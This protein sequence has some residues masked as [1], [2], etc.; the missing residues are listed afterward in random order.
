E[1]ETEEELEIR[2]RFASG[3]PFVLDDK[4]FLSLPG[5]R[6]IALAGLNIDEATARLQAVPEIAQYELNLTLLPLLPVGTAA[7][8][9]FG[10]DLFTGRPITF[11][12]ATDIPV[13]AEYVMGPGD[14]VAVQ[15]FGS[16]NVE[17]R[18]A[19]TRDG[20]LNLPEVGPLPVG[21]VTFEELK[22]L[23]NDRILEQLSGVKVSI[24]LGE[25]RSIRIFVLGDANSPGS[26]TV[27]ALSNMTNALFV[28]GGIT[29][30][31]SLRQIALRRNGVTI[32]TMDLYDLLLYG[33]TRAD[34]RLQPGDVIFIPPIGRTVAVDGMVKRPAIYELV[35]DETTVV[36]VIAL[37]GGL[38]PAADRSTVKVER[39]I[40]GRGSLVRDIDLHTEVGAGEMIQDGDVV[41][42]LSNIDQLEDVVRLAGNVQQ[43]GLFEWTPGMRL[44][45][46]LVGSELLR[47]MSDLGY[48]FI[49]REPM[50]NISI[51]AL[52][53]SLSEAWTNPG[54]PEDV[55][56]QPLDTVHVF[57]LEQGRSHIIGP[58]LKEIVS[59]NRTMPLATI[60][61]EV[62]DPGDY[63]LEEGMR[64]TDLIRASG[65]LLESSY[66]LNLEIVRYETPDNVIR[67]SRIL[68]ASLANILDGD[69][70]EDLFL[71]PYD[72]VSIRRVPDWGTDLRVELEGEVRF[73]GTYAIRV[74]ETLSSILQRA[75]GIT[76]Q[77]FAE[78]AIFLREDIRRREEEQIA[79]MADR[80]ENSLA[81]E[82]LTTTSIIG[83]DPT[84]AGQALV[85]ALRATEGS[86]RLVIDVEGILAGD[87]ASDVTLEDG[88]RLLIPNFSESV[89]VLGEVQYSS[90]HIFN[91]L[92]NRD[93]YLLLSG[94]L[95][96]GADEERI[97]VVKANGQVQTQVRGN[98]FRR[99]TR[100]T[101]SASG[102]AIIGP[103][104]TI[105]V[106]Y[107][108]DRISPLTLWQTSTQIIYN[109]AVTLTAINSVLL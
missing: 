109:V 17:H 28:S 55:L 4:G 80:L 25:L 86:G 13:P 85:S 40:P 58:I 11:A 90:T 92:L 73:P 5:L 83:S 63:P 53:A 16:V 36:D 91:E 7:L 19:I 2:T 31:G 69:L 94:G 12:P 61:G 84:Q 103:G 38:M 102:G 6:S 104:D 44:T 72:T 81:V 18:L 8:E 33:D 57:H 22:E 59:E 96:A 39:I 41:R 95:T 76:D 30:V 87:P 88:D 107:K 23:V 32:S 89:M 52:S 97:Y 75:G 35:D 108:T 34:S 20:I 46:L 9:P 21:G 45:D 101:N 93:D 43:P 106:P 99:A 100:F 56:L 15:Y 71:Q 65:G 98:W 70:S 67:E 54:G 78:G 26:Y 77:G 51:E 37:A 60:N 48:V 68:S 14:N 62:L 105:V 64:I 1:E 79:L 24:S 74:G 10:Y 82:S 47:P 42:V 50:P 3:N 66:L 27:S 29:E 49:R